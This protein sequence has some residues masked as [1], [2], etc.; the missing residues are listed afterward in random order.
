VTEPLSTGAAAAS[1]AVTGITLVSLFGPLDGPTVIGAFAGASIFIASARDFLIW[2]RL[3]LGT[4][5][6]VI[7][8][9][10]AP[11][12]AD[13]IESV[14]PHTTSVGTPI[15]ALIASAAIVRI[16]M[17]LSGKDGPSILSRFRGGTH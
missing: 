11:F 9:I 17:M 16:L 12:S 13:L 6:F 2:W 4:I 3:F 15:G 7:G 1:T 5:S 8:I 10:A 14:I